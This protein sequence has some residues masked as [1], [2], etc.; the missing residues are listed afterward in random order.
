MS[1]DPTMSNADRFAVDRELTDRESAAC[2]T[3]QRDPQSAGERDHPSGVLWVRCPHCHTP[4][5]LPGED[6]IS[7]IDCVACGGRFSLLSGDETL[8]AGPQAGRALGDFELLELLGAGQF[9]KVWKARDRR[10]DRIV[11]VKIPRKSHLSA[12]E[13]EQFFAQA[14]P[15]H[16]CN[17]RIS[18]PSMKS[19]WRTKRYTS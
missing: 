6:A 8:A 18:S 11:A 13:T 4:L 1:T 7:Q 15:P 9:G 3:T 19:G 16:R 10:L 12:A 2:Q 5:V 17:I 14:L